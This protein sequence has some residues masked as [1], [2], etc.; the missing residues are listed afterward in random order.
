MYYILSNSQSVSFVM[1]HTAYSD[2]PTLLM[3]RLASTLI[4]S[5]DD[6]S[7]GKSH[8]QSFYCRIFVAISLWIFTEYNTINR[9]VKVFPN[10]KLV[11]SHHIASLVHDKYCAFTTKHCG[12]TENIILHINTGQ[13]KLTWCNF[14]KF[15]YRYTASFH[16]NDYVFTLKRRM[17]SIYPKLTFLSSGMYWAL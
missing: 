1:F 11:A 6:R 5:T 15:K 12:Q 13:Q 4:P 14:P 9:V 3:Q 8:Q 16:D 2:E 10:L 17:C 7:W